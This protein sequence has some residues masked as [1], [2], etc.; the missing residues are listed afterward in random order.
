MAFRTF[1][2]TLLLALLGPLTAQSNPDTDELQLEGTTL[3]EEAFN[4]LRSLAGDWTDVDGTLGAKG[5]VAVSYQVT[6]NGSAVIETI[7]P[8]KPYEM[9]TVFYRDSGGLSLTHYCSLG[10]QPEM[11]SDSLSPEE[12]R[13]SLTG[14]SNFDPAVDRHMHSRRMRKVSDTEL[15]G[16]WQEYVDGAATPDLRKRYRLRRLL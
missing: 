7:F 9:I 10:N 15:E 16:E 5:E 13:F 12:I 14:G 8:G 6:G 1:S 11:Q 4:Q 2:F 3:A